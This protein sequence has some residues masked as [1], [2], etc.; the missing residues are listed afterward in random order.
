MASPPC[1]IP[2]PFAAAGQCRMAEKQRSAQVVDGR[3]NARLP[4][5][6]YWKVIG[7]IASPQSRK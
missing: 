6:G 7:P 2:T 5:S 1:I 4:L 3:Q